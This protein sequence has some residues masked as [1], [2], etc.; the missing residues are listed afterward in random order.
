D[1]RGRQELVRRGAETRATARR[2]TRGGAGELREPVSD[3]GTEDGG[4]RDR[5]TVRPGASAALHPGG[6]R[7]QHHRVLAWFRRDRDDRWRIRS[8]DAWGASGGGGTPGSGKAGGA[9]TDRRLGNPDRQS[10]VMGGRD[11]RSR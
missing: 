5:R 7:R 4:V 1:D 10:R 9:A 3:R 11:R 8:A 6:Q 2:P